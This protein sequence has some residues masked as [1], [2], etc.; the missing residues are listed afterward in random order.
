[1]APASRLPGRLAERK[2]SSRV[3]CPGRLHGRRKLLLASGLLIARREWPAHNQLVAADCAERRATLAGQT[4]STPL[5]RPTRFQRLVGS[6]PFECVY[7][8]KLCFVLPEVIFLERESE[9]G[10]Q[11]KPF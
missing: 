4:K 10:S 9:G 2:V 1:M 11:I 8:F 5:G 7:C 6:A 3:P